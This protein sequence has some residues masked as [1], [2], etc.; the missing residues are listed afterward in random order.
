M[1][2]TVKILP[3]LMAMLLLLSAFVACAGGEN[4]TTTAAAE[5]DSTPAADASTGYDPLA[6]IPVQD[7]GGY[8]YNIITP[9]HDWAICNITGTEITGDTIQDTIYSRQL[10]VEKRL[11]VKLNEISCGNGVAAKLMSQA[12]ASGE[13]A[14]DLAQ[15]PTNDAL[16]LY[17]G[18]YTADIAS[19]STIDLDNPWWEKSFNDQVNYGNKRY[20]V[21]YGNQSLIYYSSFYIFVFNK[22][23]I[24]SYNLEN[25]YDLVANNKWTW[26]K[27][28][29]M[30]T[31]VATDV[32]G[33]GSFEP[34]TDI[35]GLTGHVNHSRNILFSSG[36]TICEEDSEG[37]LSYENLSDNYITAF[38]KF[39]EYFIAS[40]F[41]ALAGVS[42]TKYA[43]YTGAA[44]VKNYISVF[45]EG[46]SL[47][48]T[49]G[50]NEILQIRETETEYGIVVV[51]KYN[52]EQENYITPVFSATAGMVI[53]V[54]CGDTERAGLVLETL[55]AYSYKNLVDKH[56]GIVLH[57]RVSQDPTAIQMINLAYSSGAIDTAM[58]NNF[59]TC[60]NMLNNLNVLGST[61]VS[62]VFTGIKSKLKSDIRDAGEKLE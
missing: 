57:Y 58:A 59:G 40:P 46:K 49:T 33:D 25:P 43:G 32:G 11:N 60:V 29:E 48:L 36:F 10:N 5:G 3:V 26:D 18:G 17:T 24:D 9:I 12:A 22:N 14:Y 23:M 55:G 31:T 7:L 44:G 19:V 30:M 27:A 38:R 2:K 34:G 56:I 51:P 1:N 53:P 8:T 6:T 47:F 54:A 41:V 4:E 35:L 42:G 50:T 28:Y 45:I 52:E 37:L 61:E 15:I 13:E 39:T 62:R 20:Y 16:S 21:A